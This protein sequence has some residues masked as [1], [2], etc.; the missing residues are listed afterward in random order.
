MNIHGYPTYFD[1]ISYQLPYFFLHDFLQWVSDEANRS[2]TGLS[3]FYTV[4]P[5]KDASST[6]AEELLSG[7]VLTKYLCIA[8][9]IYVSNFINKL[10]FRAYF[11]KWPKL[12]Q[13]R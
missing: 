5:T 8:F 13:I 3:I 6:T 12:L 4:L 1:L 2:P 11:S 7:I 10:W 9:P